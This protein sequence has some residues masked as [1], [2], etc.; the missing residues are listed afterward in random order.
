M[1]RID[2]N[3]GRIAAGTQAI[4]NTGGE[5]QMREEL[6]EAVGGLIAHA[7]TDDVP[8]HARTRAMQLVKAADLV[9]LART[10][11]ERDYQGDVID[12]HA[13]EMPTRFAKQL[14]QMLRGGVAIGMTRERGHAAGDPLRP[15]Q[16]PA[17]AA[18]ILLDLA[19]NPGSTPGRRA[20][21]HRQA[22]DHDQ[23]RD[24]SAHH[25]RHAAV[26]RRD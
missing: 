4:R 8:T 1:I 23:A 15:R 12:A 14:A 10:A 2:S 5:V 22:V 16:H 7:S 20:Q 11:V 19:A 21:A 17:A 24:G 18:R 6:A 13:P 25:A 9:T 26:R 3:I